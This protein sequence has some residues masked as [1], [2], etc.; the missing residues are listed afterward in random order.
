MLLI[1]DIDWVRYNAS[2]VKQDEEPKSLEE[3]YESIDFYITQLF[4]E[5]EADEYILCL[6]IGSN[7]RYTIFPDYKKGRKGKE[8]PNYFKEITDYITTNYNCAYGNNWEADDYIATYAKL[9]PGC[10][11]AHVD[12]DIN[13]V[14]SSL[15]YN[16]KSKEFYEVSIEEAKKL[17]YISLLTGDSGD[18]IPGCPQRGIKFAEKLL[19]QCLELGVNFLTEIIQEYIKIF[20]EEIGIQKFY[21]AYMCLKLKEDAN[22]ELVLPRKI[23][24]ND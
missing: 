9:Y 23:D 14:P 8:K 22:F 2:Y 10:I 11:I 16:S 5:T 1:A 13:Q 20:G 17:F 24:N 4:N 6:T 18:G 15:H 3:V 12:K 19:T 7:F 21:E